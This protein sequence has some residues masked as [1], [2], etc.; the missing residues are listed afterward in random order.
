MRLIKHK[1]ELKPIRSA[2]N[3]ALIAIEGEVIFDIIESNIGS[4]C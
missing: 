1:T 4:L 3:I 2:E